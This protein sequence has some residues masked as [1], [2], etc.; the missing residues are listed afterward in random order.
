M[1]ASGEKIYKGRCNTLW[2]KCFDM[3]RRKNM[4]SLLLGSQHCKKARKNCTKD[5][6]KVYE[7]AC[8]AAWDKCGEIRSRK[9]T[10]KERVYMH[11]KHCK[12]AKKGCMRSGEKLLEGWCSAA[13]STCSLVVSAKMLRDNATL[14]PDDRMDFLVDKWAQT[15]FPEVLV[16]EVIEPPPLDLPQWL[17]PVTQLLDLASERSQFV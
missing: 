10:D 9:V 15:Y 2:T 14:L 1:A 16:P 8:T 7:G 3:K 17:L 11:G 4:W 12:L 6:G 13:W 5:G